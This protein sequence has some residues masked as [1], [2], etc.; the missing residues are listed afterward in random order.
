MAK[1]S[2]VIHI[3]TGDRPWERGPFDPYVGI[4]HFRDDQYCNTNPMDQVTQGVGPGTFEGPGNAAIQTAN[5]TQ[6]LGLDSGDRGIGQTSINM[7][8]ASNNRPYVPS[9]SYGPSADEGNT[10]TGEDFRPENKGI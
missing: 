5:L 9:D 6:A 2:T 1:D 4:E 3:I 10:A 7:T 8:D